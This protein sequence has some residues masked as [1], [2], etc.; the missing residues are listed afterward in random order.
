MNGLAHITIAGQQVGLKFGMP[1]L[2]R[3]VEKMQQFDLLEG[4]ASND[5]GVVHILFAGYLNYCAMH[6]TAS[7]LAFDAFYNYVET[8]PDNPD[9][10]SELRSAVKEFEESRYVK[11]V[12]GNHK[13]KVRN[14]HSIGMTSNPSV[15]GNLGT[16]H[17]NT[18]D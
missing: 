14:D 10:V 6:D 8:A 18:V 12:V 17:G 16:R 9:T 11:A 13:K 15:S 2:R 5:L 3:I 7:V 4:D 1:A